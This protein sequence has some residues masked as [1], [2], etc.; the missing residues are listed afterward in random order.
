MLEKCGS[1]Y[2][3]CVCACVGCIMF[4][5]VGVSTVGQCVYVCVDGGEGLCQTV[6]IV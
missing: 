2:L 6:Y 5:S 1:A 4:V 3:V